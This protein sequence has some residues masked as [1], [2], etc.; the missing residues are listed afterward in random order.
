MTLK[1]APTS[2]QLWRSFSKQITFT[3]AAGRPHNHV[4]V[5]LLS[6]QIAKQKPNIRSLTH[7]SMSC[8][9]PHQPNTQAAPWPQILRLTHAQAGAQDLCWTVLLKAALAVLHTQLLVG[10]VCVRHNL[11]TAVAI[12]VGA[13]TAAL[14]T[15]ALLPAALL[16]AALLAAAL[17]HAALLTAALLPAALLIAALLHAA[18]MPAALLPAD[19]PEQGLGFD[20]L[21]AA[22]VIASPLDGFVT[23]QRMQ[24]EVQDVSVGKADLGAQALSEWGGSPALH[25]DQHCLSPSSPVAFA[26]WTTVLSHMWPE[27]LFLS[28]QS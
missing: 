10:D 3:Q 14:L 17:L 16:P 9:V 22:G 8:L 28:A 5:T 13:L 6:K 21:A 20:Q 19:S 27:V 12:A 11:P 26:A 18:A 1:H 7:L 4:T 25:F 23:G 15:A 24:N 2:I